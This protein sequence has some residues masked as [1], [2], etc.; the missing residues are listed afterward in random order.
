VN[1]HGAELS[2]LLIMAGISGI[3]HRRAGFDLIE[4]RVE[5]ITYPKTD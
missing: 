2:R 5:A 4:I 1:I 3:P